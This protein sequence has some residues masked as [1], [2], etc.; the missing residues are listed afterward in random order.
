[1]KLLFILMSFSLVGHVLVTEL[2]DYINQ[3]LLINDDIRQ[4]KE[5]MPSIIK[6]IIANPD[7]YGMEQMAIMLAVPEIIHVRLRELDERESDSDESSSYSDESMDDKLEESGPSQNKIPDLNLDPSTI[8]EEESK[9]LVSVGNTIIHLKEKLEYQ[10]T[11]Q[12]EILAVTDRP[13]YEEIMQ[14]AISDTPDPVSIQSL[15]LNLPPDYTEK[16]RI[17]A[18]TIKLENLASVLEKRRN[19]PTAVP[20]KRI[21]R[22]F[23][24]SSLGRARREMT[25]EAVQFL[26]RQN[27]PLFKDLEMMCRL[28]GLF[29]SIKYP[30]SFISTVF[31]DE[32][33]CSLEDVT[34]ATIFVYTFI[35]D[36]LWEVEIGNR[37]PIRPFFF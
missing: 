35:D 33:Y 13:K 18:P 25:L 3:V 6:N 23:G 22:S 31:L 4:A 8:S 19:H 20:R 26:I 27:D 14:A 32:P 30:L 34:G 1:M 9:V 28:A 36:D 15:D 11:L 21:I 29:R 7:E 10:K 37:T 24:L 17:E 5:F 16:G 2:D 12:L